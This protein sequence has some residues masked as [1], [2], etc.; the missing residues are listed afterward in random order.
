M[1]TRAARRRRAYARLVGVAPA[2]RLAPRIPTT[3]AD[4][5]VDGV[6]PAWRRWCERW[7]ATSTLQ[8]SSRI[9]ILYQLFQA[10][11]WLGQTHPGLEEPAD[12]TRETAAD[13]VA[14]VDRSAV[15]QWSTPVGAS[16]SRVG[17]PRSARGKEASLKALRTFFA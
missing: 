14:A 13:F 9:G 17:Q 11:R 15:G 5:S 8:R 7:F 16:A 3:S 1:T 4:V 6:P 12:W 2:R 10:G